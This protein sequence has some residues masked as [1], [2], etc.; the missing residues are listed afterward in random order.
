MSNGAIRY[1]V[2]ISK[3]STNGSFS[4]RTKV[5]HTKPTQA[6]IPPVSPT[7]LPQLP[8]PLPPT[9]PANTEEMAFFD[10]AKKFIGNKQSFNEFLKL[11]N[12]FTQDVIDKHIL[13]DRAQGFIGSS[14]DLMSWFRRFIEGEPRDDTI[15][16]RPQPDSGRV[17]LSH[18]RMLG[19]S[20]RLLPKRERSKPC[21]GRDQI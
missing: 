21:S 19:P 2:L 4:Q 13:L 15:E 17:N 16:P 11:C 6:D 7:L 10:R 5:H 9:A 8:E 14:P 12:L 1:T 3:Y 20:Y 18:C